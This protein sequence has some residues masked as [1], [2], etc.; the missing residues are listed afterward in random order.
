MF[1]FNKKNRG[2]CC[3][4]FMTTLLSAGCVPSD[5]GVKNAPAPEVD[6]FPNIGGVRI[7]MPQR[8]VIAF[9]G[10]P[11]DVLDYGFREDAHFQYQGLD[12]YLTA[13]GMSLDSPKVVVGV[14][15]VSSSFCF[16]GTVCP[17]ATRG[18]VEEYFRETER[19]L[20][21]T[22]T[23]TRVSWLLPNTE[24]C[25]VKF[26]LDNALIVSRVE[27]ACQP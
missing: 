19:S 13:G 12:I 4:F 21:E 17:G 2:F 15:A 11:E 1:R 23:S 24:G 10:E 5:L 9:F 18:E 27:I 3:G 16:D 22:E 7:G 8:E 26:D 6:V 20:I 25:W 14:S